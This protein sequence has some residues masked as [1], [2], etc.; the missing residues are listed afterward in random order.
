[1]GKAGAPPSSPLGRLLVDEDMTPRPPSSEELRSILGRR[2]GTQKKDWVS[3][4]RLRE[5]VTKVPK[6]KSGDDVEILAHKPSGASSSTDA[7]PASSAT[8]TAKRKKVFDPAAHVPEGILRLSKRHRLT[9]AVNTTVKIEPPERVG[10]SAGTR[11]QAV[12]P[13]KQELTESGPPSGAAPNPC[14]GHD[15]RSEL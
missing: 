3:L 10:P 1:M 5:P 8:S 4:L 9:P 13:V 12:R 7:A 11:S 15:A 14:A 6:V 2:A